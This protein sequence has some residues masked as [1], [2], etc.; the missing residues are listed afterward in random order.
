MHVVLTT[1]PD[2]DMVVNGLI[3]YEPDYGIALNGTLATFDCNKGFG[4][5]GNRARLCLIDFVSL[6]ATWTGNSATCEST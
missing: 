3:L 2:L 5:V 6:N 1:C 4:V